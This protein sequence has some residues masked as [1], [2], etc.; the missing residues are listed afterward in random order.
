MLNCFASR[1]KVIIVAV[2]AVLAVVC[3]AATTMDDLPALVDSQSSRASS[4]IG[5][6]SNAS[7]TS[8]Q[9]GGGPGTPRSA[10]GG[11][12]GCT[13]PRGDGSER[14]FSRLNLSASFAGVSDGSAYVSGTSQGKGEGTFHCK[15][16]GLHLSLSLRDPNRPG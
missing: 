8:T 5:L 11:G 1:L 6:K 4:P 7:C 16:C 3:C 2:F 10:I 15:R 9:P 14:S 12:S 13:T